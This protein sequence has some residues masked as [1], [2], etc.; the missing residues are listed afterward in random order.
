M[1]A[2]LRSLVIIRRVNGGS[3]GGN[4]T[5]QAVDAAQAALDK[6]DLA[7]AV[8]ALG[9]LSGGAATAAQPW[10]KDAQERLDAEQTV[11]KLSRDLAGDMAA[12]ASGG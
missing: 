12:G 1:W 5:D 9:A 11:A 7:G 6:G 10:L 3:T 2:R 4:P 8:K